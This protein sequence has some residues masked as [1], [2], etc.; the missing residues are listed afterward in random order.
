MNNVRP[1]FDQDQNNML[2]NLTKIN[3]MS[4]KR[5]VNNS[6][7]LNN[8]FTYQIIHEQFNWTKQ[9]EVI[10]KEQCEGNFLLPIKFESTPITIAL[11]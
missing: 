6:I 2:N 7:W 8:L 3:N 4:N 5:S 1:I 9:S 10:H 11:G